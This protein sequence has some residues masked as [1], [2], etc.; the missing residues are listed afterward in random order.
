M[1]VVTAAVPSFP[2]SWRK[3]AMAL[4]LS[5]MALAGGAVHAHG[6]EAAASP[7]AA[8][9]APTAVLPGDDFYDYVNGDWMRATAIP[10]DRASWGS[11]AILADET[12]QRIIAL[13]EGLQARQGGSA[14][15]R[16]VSDFYR[17]YMDEAAIEAKGWAPLKPLLKKIDAVRD[18]AGLARALGESLRA[19]VDPLNSTNFYTENLFGLWV[20]Q[21]LN[22]PTRNVAYL[23]QGGLGMP[24]RAYYATDSARMQG[25][26]GSYQAH[27]AAMLQLAGYGDA[28]G[29]A[30]RVFAL[31]Q[32]IAASHA[33]REESADVAKGN[34]A[35]RAGDFASKAPGLDWKAFFQAAG[36]GAQKDFIVWHPSAMTG[37]AALVASVPLATWKDFLAF[38]AINHFGATLP[39]AAAD[40]RFAFYGSALS[41]TPQQSPR[42]K[43]ALAA[44]NGA[45]S[46]AVGKLYV[47]RYFPPESKARVQDM[48]ANIVAAFSRRIDKLDWMAPE[49]RAQA[50]EK[51]KTLY[52]GV[53]YPERWASYAGLRVVRGDAL[54]NAQRAEQF[55]YQQQ[56]AKLGQPVDR[57]AW[58][59]PAQLV[60]A[61][62]LP[63]QNALNFPAA[64][65]QP[66]FFDPQASDA[67]N[68]GGIGATI[69]HEISHS[70]DDQGAQFDAQGKLR[71]WWTPADLAHFKTAAG[72][73]AA[74][75][76]AYRPFPD[77]AVNGQ[78]TLSENL[79]DLAGV[80]AAYDAFTLSQQGKAAQPGAERAFF[81]GYGVSWRSKAREAA[82]RQQ[83]LTDGHAPAQYRAA[84]V[85][86][87]DAWYPVFDVQPG[88]QLY[89]APEQ[90]VRVW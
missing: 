36:L 80:A 26:R 35:W 3:R 19:D 51:L 5:G 37:S 55:H 57:K 68:Y 17:S 62:N 63:L 22:D 48:V 1:R 61:V 28:Q 75:F 13:V 54:G 46:D 73:L 32:Q 23:L 40:Q 34:N 86:N 30:A 33:S 87:L 29:R 6:Q 9:A 78:L 45:L 10:D 20:A 82:A 58:A 14:E 38:H 59:M 12:N 90:R 60:N 21:D 49:T 11:F 81:T 88:Q 74:Q 24:D 76:S 4:A 53:G 31:E 47:E 16:Q 2:G 44:T 64:I 41:G 85:R 79:A 56:L 69:G 8:K 39:K 50:Q 71:D 66:P 42:S 89:L 43:R 84:T 77:L 83:I 52:V 67:A 18:Q 27:I 72:Q 7:A 65:L 15:A 25:L 70:F